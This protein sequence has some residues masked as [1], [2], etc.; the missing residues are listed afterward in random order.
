[1]RNEDDE[2]EEDFIPFEEVE[3]NELED[4]TNSYFSDGEENDN[5]TQ[6]D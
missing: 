5:S 6:N 2:E 1:M 3:S 4:A